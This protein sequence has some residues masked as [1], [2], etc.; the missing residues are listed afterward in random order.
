MKAFQTK[1]VCSVTRA[2]NADV[3]PVLRS[4]LRVVLNYNGRPGFRKCR[5]R[6]PPNVLRDSERVTGG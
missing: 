5:G 6:P 4:P 1:P 2:S 3:N